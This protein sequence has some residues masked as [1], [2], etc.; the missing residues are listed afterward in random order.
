MAYRKR[1]LKKRSYTRKRKT[2]KRKSRKSKATQTIVRSPNGFPDRFITNCRSHLT[3]SLYTTLANNYSSSMMINSVTNPFGGFS[4]QI[5]TYA[6]TL[7]NIYLRYIVRAVEITVRFV[8]NSG[9]ATYVIG[10]PN[11]VYASYAGSYDIAME[12]PYS[13]HG[14]LEAN[15]AGCNQILTLKWTLNLAKIVGRTNSEYDKSDTFASAVGSNPADQIGFIISG[16]DIISTIANLFVICDITINQHVEF[17]EK[18]KIA[19]S[20]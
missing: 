2:M 8:Q 19:N 10:Y 14:I 11:N 6:Q 1:S 18:Q 15:T 9:N 4:A 12:Q 16:Y 3:C 5:A 13:K 17:F 7:D 20:T